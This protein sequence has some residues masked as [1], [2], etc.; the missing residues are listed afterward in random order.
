MAAVDKTLSDVIH[1]LVGASTELADT[2]LTGMALW[3]KLKERGTQLVNGLDQDDV[4]SVFSRNGSSKAYGDAVLPGKSYRESEAAKVS[5]DV[6]SAM[7]RD[8]LMRYRTRVKM[9]HHAAAR[10]ATHSLGV[11]PVQ[12]I[13]KYVAYILDSGKSEEPATTLA[14]T[15][16]DESTAEAAAAEE[17][18]ADS[19]D[20]NGEGVPSGANSSPNAAPY[21]PAKWADEVA[22]SLNP[23][24]KQIYDM[25]NGTDTAPP[26]SVSEISAATGMPPSA[27]NQ[28]LV[29]IETEIAAGPGADFDCDLGET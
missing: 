19:D 1:A 15:D 8:T 2:Q 24:D 6:L 7:E 13:L 28:I 10:Q 29:G 4:A 5:G 27:V 17:A 18:A 22:D 23:V 14:S 16:D 3:V 11:G 20:G 9:V 21:D 26:Q 12:G 25:Y